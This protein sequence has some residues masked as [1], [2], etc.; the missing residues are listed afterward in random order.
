M[1]PNLGNYGPALTFVEGPKI[2][3]HRLLLAAG[4]ND[5]C[6]MRQLAGMMDSVQVQHASGTIGKN[7][8]VPFLKV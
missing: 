3:N 6:Y 7:V 1:R 4:G 2:S 5:G 8:K